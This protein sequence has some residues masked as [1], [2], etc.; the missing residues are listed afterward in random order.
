M[1]PHNY[2]TTFFPIETIVVPNVFPKVCYRG[3]FNKTKLVTLL[4]CN[5]KNISLE[6]YMEPH[7]CV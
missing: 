1:E 5:S 7:F 6:P 4:F 2:G 3:Y